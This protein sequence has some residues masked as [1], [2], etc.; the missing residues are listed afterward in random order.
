MAKQ[1]KTGHVLF[2]LGSLD[3][4][5]QDSGGEGRESPASPGPGAAG[6]HSGRAT[7]PPYHGYGRSLS[8]SSAK[9]VD[10]GPPLDPS[11]KP[12]LLKTMPH[13]ND[14]FFNLRKQRT[15]S[16]S[17]AGSS[18]EVDLLSGPTSPLTS[19]TH[20]PKSTHFLP[21]AASVDTPEIEARILVLYSGGTIGMR[22]NK[23]DGGECTHACATY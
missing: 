17:S 4:Q 8:T 22:T 12:K 14:S 21:K 20:A 5:D 9:S 23:E 6:G 1:E 13:P 10:S 19:P 7:S 16:T 18:A 15:A 11:Y 3:L 2:G